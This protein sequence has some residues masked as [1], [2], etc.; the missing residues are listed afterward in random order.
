[1]VQ[2]WLLLSHG[3]R[4]YP[5]V[6]QRMFVVNDFNFTYLK[7]TAAENQAAVASQIDFSLFIFD[8]TSLWMLFQWYWR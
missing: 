4:I 6:R 1:M 8:N 7:A 5:V 3:S 2:K